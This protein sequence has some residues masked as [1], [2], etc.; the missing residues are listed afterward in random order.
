N[1]GAWALQPALFLH[2]ALTFPEKKRFLQNR[3]WFVGLIYV[4]AI[5]LV[6]VQVVALK[7]FAATESLRWSLDRL[8]WCYLTFYFIVAATVLWRRYRAAHIPI[9]RQQLKWIS[10]GT[11]LAIAPFTLLYVIPYLY[12]AVAAPI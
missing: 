1:V 6:A 4:P 8:H 10:R 3:A 7:E 9:V 12:G 11:V 5:V 2:F